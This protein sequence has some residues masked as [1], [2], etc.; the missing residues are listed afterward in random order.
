MFAQIGSVIDTKNKIIFTENYVAMDYS[1]IVSYLAPATI[2]SKA[3][4][5]GFFGTGT[6]ITFENQGVVEEYKVIVKGD[7]NGDSVCDV[8]DCM[9]A[10]LIRTGNCEA[11][12][13]QI[14]AANNDIADKVTVEDFQ[15]VINWALAR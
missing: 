5:Y 13:E 1:K 7:L 9:L 8:L 12:Q 11:T 14:Y 6:S 15:N 2:T 4:Q 3:N 10:E